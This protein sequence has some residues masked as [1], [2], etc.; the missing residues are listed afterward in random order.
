MKRNL[1][2]R[3]ASYARMWRRWRSLSVENRVAI[4]GLVV[5]ILA[6]VPGYLVLFDNGGQEGS[7]PAA[8][9]GVTNTSLR[10][11]SSQGTLRLD[12]AYFRAPESIIWAVPRALPPEDDPVIQAP[13]LA[14][15][16]PAQNKITA[17]LLKPTFRS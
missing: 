3:S 16:D 10:Q 15:N 2:R 14:G 8:P 4:I 11:P 5:A 1:N 12:A 17:L 9:S 7:S 6:A 13:N